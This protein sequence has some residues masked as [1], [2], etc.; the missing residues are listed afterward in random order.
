ME[1]FENIFR[2]SWRWFLSLSTFSKIFYLFLLAIVATGI[3]HKTLEEQKIREAKLKAI[4]RR[5]KKQ[6]GKEDKEKIDDFLLK[7]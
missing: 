2:L 5:E 7:P 6:D 4:R 3:I 1:L